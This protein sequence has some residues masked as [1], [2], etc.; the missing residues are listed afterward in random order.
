MRC[1]EEARQRYS[2]GCRVGLECRANFRRY[3]EAWDLCPLGSPEEANTVYSLRATWVLWRCH[4]EK[5]AP[6]SNRWLS[7]VVSAAGAE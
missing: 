4:L 1:R 5:M 6:Y 7:H 3:G 2:G